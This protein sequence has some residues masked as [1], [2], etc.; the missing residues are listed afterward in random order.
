MN[1]VAWVLLMTVA[2][3]P[4]GAQNPPDSAMP[5]DAAGA[6]ELREQIQQ[7]WQQ[8]VRTTLGLTDEQA[9]K[10]RDSEQRFETQRQ[11]IRGRQ[12]D[13]NQRLDTEL[14]SGSPNQDRVRQ[15]IT[16]RDANRARLQQVDRDQD[17]EMGGYLTPVQRARYQQARQV[18]RERVAELIR[19]RREQGRA[20][21][22]PPRAGRAPAPKPPPR[23]RKP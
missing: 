13:L 12:R 7:R 4:L 15:L 20:A 23:R 10:L 3:A 17:Q 1:C 5:Q 21:P 8:H 22:A 18:F 16:E 9:A 19:H 6:K 14:Q 2:A 11:Q